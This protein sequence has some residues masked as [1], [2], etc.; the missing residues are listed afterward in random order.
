MLFNPKTMKSRSGFWDTDVGKKGFWDTGSG[1]RFQQQ[2]P[3]QS[4]GTFSRQQNRFGVK[5]FNQGT[6]LLS[7]FNEM[8]DPLKG[9]LGGIA[10]QLQGLGIPDPSAAQSYMDYEGDLGKKTMREGALPG[11]MMNLRGLGVA[12]AV[13]PAAQYQANVARNA[14]DARAGQYRHWMNFLKEPGL[15]SAAASLYGQGLGSIGSM[16]GNTLSDAQ[17]YFDR[18]VAI[19]GQ[20]QGRLS[21]LMNLQRE[22][23]NRDRAWQRQDYNRDLDWQRGEWDRNFRRKKQMQDY[24]FNAAKNKWQQEQQEQS[25]NQRRDLM[26]RMYLT[27][28]YGWN[29]R[30]G[31]QGINEW[32]IASGTARPPAWTMEQAGKL[33]FKPTF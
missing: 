23:Y 29:D 10:A 33:G 25:L 32:L 8:L 16:Y 27:R 4:G 28:P 14:A 18:D 24:M 9:G 2:N 21:E 22:D 12:G 11:Q 19:R 17:R 20:E 26:K 30:T 5:R 6:G 1:K 15:A 3:W 13:N 7:S 31:M